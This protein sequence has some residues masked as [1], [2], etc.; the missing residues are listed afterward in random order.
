[1]LRAKAMVLLAGFFR[2]GLVSSNDFFM[3]RVYIRIHNNTAT[4]IA[5]LQEGGVN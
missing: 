5:V 3:W 1:M 2:Y 4:F